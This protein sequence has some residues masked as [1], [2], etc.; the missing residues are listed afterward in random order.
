MYEDMGEYRHVIVN[1]KMR[2]SEDIAECRYERTIENTDI[3]DDN[4]GCGYV[5]I[6]M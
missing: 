2:M 1:E 3:Y 5:K 4:L 6:Q